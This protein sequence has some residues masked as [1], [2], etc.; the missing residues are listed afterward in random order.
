MHLCY[1][2]YPVISKLMQNFTQE[3]FS[4]TCSR[5]SSAQE[6]KMRQKKQKLPILF[7]CCCFSVTH[8]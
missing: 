1:L 3:M 7:L 6:L 5:G 2:L 4:F 8:M